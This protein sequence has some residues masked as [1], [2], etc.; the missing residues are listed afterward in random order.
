M[1]GTGPTV[2]RDA[3]GTTREGQPV[4]R[5]TLR[6][7]RGMCVRLMTYGG[8]ILSIE[9]PDRR[10][11]TDDVVLGYA[12]LADYE[13]LS[14]SI[15][16]GAL[17]GRYANRI[18]GARFSLGG[19]TYELAP[20]DSGNTLHGGLRGFDK[21]V[22]S[23]APHAGAA[24]TLTTTSADGDEGFP[25]TVRMHVTYALT[26]ANELRIDYEATTDKATVLNVTNHS[27]FNL[28]GNG[29]GD[30]GGLLLCV[31]ADRFTPV[32]AN[33]IPTGEFA[34][35]AG[36]PL[37]F[38]E[39]TPLGARLRS[40]F[41]QMVHARGYDHN[42]VL[43]K[44]EPGELSFA[45]RAYDPA[46]GRVLD[47]FTT[48]PGLQVYTGNFLDGTTVGSAG[49]AYRQ[50]DGFTLETQHFPDSPNQP[51]FPSTELRPGETFRSTTVFR[52]ATDAALPPMER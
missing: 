18:G 38:R 33:L 40:G 32:G 34:P 9:V 4:E 35:V 24:A 16:F 26:D 27:Y 15:Y 43:N 50:G 31:N 11:R 23:V 5:V 2:E 6:S 47:C 10:G 37:D 25:G 22:W 3:F 28:A 51:A 30:V 44:R 20:N 14:G 21:V 41:P 8:V 12:T 45:A 39:M 19:K 7:G 49:V 17:I 42:F 46:S 13:A 36:T 1:N 48:Q 52:F 29:S